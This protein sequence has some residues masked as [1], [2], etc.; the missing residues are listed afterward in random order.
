MAKRAY[1]N[2][3]LEVF[4]GIVKKCGLNSI[5]GQTKENQLKV[6]DRIHFQFGDL[7]VETKTRQVVIEIDVTLPPTPAAR[8]L[9]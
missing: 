7:R 9:Q 1:E 4:Q 6:N 2:A 3:A 8:S 5:S